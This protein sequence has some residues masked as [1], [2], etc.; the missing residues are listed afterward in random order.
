MFE[1]ITPEQAGISSRKVAEYIA[2]LERRG[3]ATHSV[4]MM[5]GDKIFAECYWAPFNKDFCHRMYSQTKSYVGIAIGLLVDDGKLDL[6]AKIASFFP[7]KIDKPLAPELAEQTVRQMLTMTTCGKSPS[8]FRSEDPDRTHLYFQPREKYRPAGT[9]WEYDSPGSQVLTNLVEKLAGKKLFDFMY[10]RMFSHMGTFQTAKILQT[11]NGD[12]WGDSALLCTTRDMASFG[13]LLMKN[14]NWNGKQLI[15]EAYVKEAT[16]KVVD[17]RQDAHGD[18]WSR[19]YGYQIWRTDYNSFGFNGMGC[20]M[21]VCCPDKDVLFTITSDNQGNPTA[22]NSIIGGVMDLILSEIS[23]EPLPADKEAEAQLANVTKDLKLRAV[24]GEADSSLREE[25]SG[26]TYVCEENPLGMERFCFQ[27]NG[28]DEGEFHYTNAQGDKVIPFGI[29]K[30]VFGK[31]PQL[32]YANEKG[33]VPTTD[34]FMYDD[35][36]SLCWAQENRIL[37]YIQIIDQYFGN[38]SATF[39]F[40][41]DYVTCHFERAAEH[42]LTEYEG[43]FVAKRTE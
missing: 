42:F 11:P 12:S 3:L 27:F 4:L 2:M 39:G 43:E 36:V 7:E 16:S 24:Q 13:R 1:R 6:D 17:N 10:E 38:C 29:N 22:K 26:V 34:G 30:N 25:V 8:W 18:F 32:G 5:K 28:T 14:G 19:G 37:M 35:A 33:R 23:D 31:F 15:S 21:T 20:Q 40:S 41:G 9:L